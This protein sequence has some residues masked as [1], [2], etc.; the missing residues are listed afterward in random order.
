MKPVVASIVFAALAGSA[1]AS[2]AKGSRPRRVGPM[3]LQANSAP[4]AVSMEEAMQMKFEQHEKDQKA[5]V[6]AKNRYVLQGPTSCKDGKAGEYGCNKLDLKGFL[7]HQDLQ[8]QTRR[9]NDIWGWTSPDG[10]EFA[11]VGETDGTAFV[12]VLS[13][14][15]LQYYGRLNTQTIPAI[16]RDIKVI[17]NHAY[18]GSES[19]DHGIQIFDLT[20]LLKVDPKSPPSFSTRSDLTAHFTGFGS[21]HNVVANEETKTIFV[22][23]TSRSEKCRGGPWMIDVSNPR[24]PQDNGCVAPS[25]GYTHDAQCLIYNGPQRDYQGHEVCLC[26]N[27]DSLDIVDISRRPSPRVLSRT[28]YKG[29]SYTHQGWLATPDQRYL[30]LDDEQDEM[31][32]AGEAAD[33]HTTTYI[34]DVSDLTHPVFTGVY[35][36]PVKAIDH[37]QYIHDGVAYQGNYGSGLRMVNVSTIVE[38]DSGSLFR[39][40]GFFDVRP[41]D[42]AEGGAVTFNGA[43][44]VYPYFKSGYILVNSIERGVFSLKFT[45]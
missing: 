36:S 39:E 17:G 6:F 44:S 11:L 5:G 37:N 24:Y 1:L 43:W 23:G 13:D 29:A 30:L 40:I 20:K 38:D 35:K 22:V 16:W 28:T 2:P 8:S 19:P 14:G 31:K 4:N 21:S 41:E 42:D 9:G 27:E 7:R 32:G 45:G 25:Q 33:G 15:Q 12:E 3:A 18:I 34:V 10:R 26:Y